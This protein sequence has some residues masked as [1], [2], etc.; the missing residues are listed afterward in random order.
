[1][2]KTL[3][4]YII[5]SYPI[6]GFTQWLLVKEVKLERTPSAYSTDHEGNIYI[7]YRDGSLVKYD[8]LGH[9]LLNF[10]LSNLS[11]ISLIEP[12]FQ[13][14]TFLFY[15][16]NQTITILDRFNAVPKNYLIRDLTAGIVS[17]ACPAPDGSFWLVEN[18]PSVLKR[19]DPNRLS[20]I[21][22]VQPF[23]GK[24]IQFM[25][26]VQNILL[27]VDEHGIHAFDQFGGSIYQLRWKLKDVRI[28]S[29]KIY[30]LHD[31]KLKTLDLLSGKLLEEIK[32]P[33][34][35]IDGLVNTDPYWTFLEGKKLL[36]FKLTL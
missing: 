6:V 3:L 28:S 14:K 9:E 12:Q 16:D 10:S 25:K 31:A 7:G 34:I 8:A 36:F 19:I 26:V 23:L 2:A 4:Y 32:P 18:N 24:D 30:C 35:A 27:I 29:N 1:M 11:T 33:N 21:L 17:M 5:L 15:F 20:P 13:L 22:E